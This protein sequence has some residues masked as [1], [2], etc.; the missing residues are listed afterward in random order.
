[1]PE[2]FISVNGISGGLLKKGTYI[3]QTVRETFGRTDALFGGQSLGMRIPLF[4]HSMATIRYRQN[5]IS[6]F[7]LSD[8]RE[9]SDHNEKAALLYTA[10]KER[11]G[12]SRP[13][14]FLPELQSLIQQVDGLNSLSAA[15]TREEIDEVIKELPTDKAPGPDGFNGMFTKRCWHIIKHDFYE[16]CKDF[17]DGK[18]DLQSI[19]DSFITLIPKI[20]A[21]ETPNDFRPIS[22]LNS[23]LKILTKLF[24]NRLQS[25]ILKL[26]HKNQYGFIKSRT[27]QDC[28]AWAFE[29]LFQCNQS[30]KQIIVFKIDFTKAFDMMEH[31]VIL[32]IFKLK[33][34]DE[35]WLNCLEHI[36][37]SG[38]SS[39]LLNGVPGKKIPLQESCSLGRPFVSTSIR[40]HC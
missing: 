38:T 26:V 32:K 40:W 13:I 28:L 35:I 18:V 4:F 8:G 29:Y 20:H 15:F 22:L 19:N 25:K 16:L 21:P 37:N 7:T 1:M 17:L 30:G 34:F 10:Y 9:V 12:Q 31:A 36:M 14:H 11:L 23:C 33:G 5:N 27:I 6:K 39:V 24:A 3:Y 2:N